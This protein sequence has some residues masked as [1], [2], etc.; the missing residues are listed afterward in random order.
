VKLCHINSTGSGFLRHSVYTP[1]PKTGPLLH[2]Q[3]TSTSLTPYQ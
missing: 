3:S 2:F 1:C